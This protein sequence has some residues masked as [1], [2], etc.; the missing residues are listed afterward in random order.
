MNDIIQ[1]ERMKKSENNLSTYHRIIEWMRVR[2]GRRERGRRCEG[3]D[4]SHNNLRG[5]FRKY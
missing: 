5:V 3:S 4:V 1:W 2:R